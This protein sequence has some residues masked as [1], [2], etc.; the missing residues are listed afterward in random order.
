MKEILESGVLGRVLATNLLVTDDLF[1]KFHADKRHSHDQTNG[2][3]VRYTALAGHKLM[4]N[5]PRRREHCH[6]CRRPSH[7]RVDLF[8]RGAPVY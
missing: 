4:S 8:A 5:L 2:E 3:S 7:R 1:L 6:N